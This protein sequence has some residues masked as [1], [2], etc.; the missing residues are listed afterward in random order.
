VSNRHS[1]LDV[2]KMDYYA[3]DQKRTLGMGQVDY[4]LIEEAFVAR[5]ECPKPRECWQCRGRKDGPGIHLMLA[6]PEKLVVKAM[7]FFKTRFS[8]H[9]N[10]YTHKTVKAVEYVRERSGHEAVRAKRGVGGGREEELTGA[11]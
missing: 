7:E 1:G 6:W 3:R 4:M 5:G 10:V 8:M 9:S 11:N 2:D